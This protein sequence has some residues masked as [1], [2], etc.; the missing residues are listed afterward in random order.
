MTVRLEHGDMREVL[1]R[2]KEEG[3]RVHAVVCDPPYHLTSIV[4]RFRDPNDRG[5]AR[6]A[7]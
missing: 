5:G 2:L 3:A 6:A 7:R 4:R 1:K